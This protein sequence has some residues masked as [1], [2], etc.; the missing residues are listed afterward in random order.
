MK[1]ERINVAAVLIIGADFA[2]MLAALMLVLPP[3]SYA[4][5]VLAPHVAAALVMVVFGPYLLAVS[6]CGILGAFLSIAHLVLLCMLVRRVR[7][8][9]ALGRWSWAARLLAVAFGALLMALSIWCEFPV[10]ERH[11]FVSDKVK[12]EFVRLAVISDLHSCAYGGR[13]MNL[14]WEVA[15]TNPDAVLFAGDIFDDRLPD[16]NARQFITAVVKR[17]P[18]FYVS[19]NH[20]YWSER[21]D[22]MKAWLRKAGVTVLEGAC[23]TLTVNGTPIDICGVDD[24]TYMLDEQWLWQLRRADRL[25]NPN[26]VRIL[27]SHRPERVSTYEK[28]AFDLILTGHAHGGQWLIPFLGRGG[29]SPDQHFF[30]KYVDGR[31]LLANGSEML[32]SRGLA[33]ESTP[34]PR[35]FNPPEIMV[36]ELMGSG[37]ARSRSS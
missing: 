12:G 20:E 1:G 3:T 35:L 16:D 23:Q 9:N 31:Y 25:S 32:V 30:P 29:Y 19:G 36:V 6:S 34:L 17:Y 7:A 4:W 18:C 14:F 33:R 15:E 8:F 28:F 13:Q 2:M 26:H 24:P 10:V 5:P 22:G 21:I 37:K 27:L 11:A